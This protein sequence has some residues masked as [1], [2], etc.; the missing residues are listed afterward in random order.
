MIMDGV[1]CGS[2]EPWLA[3]YWGPMHGSGASVI[4]T[5]FNVGLRPLDRQQLRTLVHDYQLY[6]VTPPGGS[7]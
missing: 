5:N 6:S 4:V 7:F 1:A 3:M 2:V